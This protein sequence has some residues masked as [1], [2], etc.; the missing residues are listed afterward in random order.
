MSGFI[1]IDIGDGDLLDIGDEDFLIIGLSDADIEF[2][3]TISHEIVYSSPIANDIRFTSEV[4][5]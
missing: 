4:K 1:F 3:S 2:T 5:V